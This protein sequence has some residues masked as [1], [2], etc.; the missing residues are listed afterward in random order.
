GHAKIRLFNP[1][2]E[3]NGWSLEHTV[4][5]IVNDDMPFLVDSVSA[6]INRRDRTI[7]LLLH[8]VLRVRREQHG[9]R[10]EITDTLAA[11]TDVVVESYMHIEIDQETEQSELDNLRESIERVLSQ[12]RLAVTD[13]RTMRAKLKE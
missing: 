13:W 1:S 12:V 2:A 11:P 8:P 6:E 4:I 10:V 3:K 7:H 5:E 9:R